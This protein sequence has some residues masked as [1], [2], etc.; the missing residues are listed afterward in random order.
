M[1]LRQQGIQADGSKI[2]HERR[3]GEVCTSA[4]DVSQHALTSPSS[5]APPAAPSTQ[6][7]HLQASGSSSCPCMAG[8]RGK[9]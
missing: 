6:F 9:W 5:R 7:A 8:G 1:S 4:A 2:E 3:N